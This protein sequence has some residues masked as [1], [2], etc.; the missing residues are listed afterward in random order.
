M[1]QKAKRR[2]WSAG[3]LGLFAV[4]GWLA[5]DLLGL[6]G[7]QRWILR[8]IMLLVGL[9]AAFLVHR[10]L[11]KRAP[12]DADRDGGAKEVDQLFSEVRRRLAIDFGGDDFVVPRIAQHNER[13]TLF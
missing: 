4:A 1:K 5:G 8:G 2:A 11:S 3:T 12:E 9:I 13:E 6:P 10:L 7:S